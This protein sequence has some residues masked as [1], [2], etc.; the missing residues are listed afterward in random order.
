VIRP[1]TRDREIRRQRIGRLRSAQGMFGD[2]GFERSP[3]SGAGLQ[4]LPTRLVSPW[5]ALAHRP[6]CYRHRQARAEAALTGRAT[7]VPFTAVV[8]GPERT[9]TDNDTV[10]VTCVAHHLRRL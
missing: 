1:A 2:R 9:P 6:S 5:T 7:S 3:R 10:A 8:T 4:P